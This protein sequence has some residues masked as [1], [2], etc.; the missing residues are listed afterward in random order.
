[1]DLPFGPT[2]RSASNSWYNGTWTVFIEVFA[3]CVDVFAG[4]VDVFAGCVDVF[5][6]CV[7]VF[8]GCVDVFACCVDELQP[9]IAPM[10]NAM[11]I[12]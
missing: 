8:A 7:D 10:A 9:L 1:M 4:C 2:E 5:A 6:G 11:M 3:G 12:R